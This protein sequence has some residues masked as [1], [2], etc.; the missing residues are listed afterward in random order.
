MQLHPSTSSFALAD[1]SLPHATVRRVV[2]SIRPLPHSRLTKFSVSLVQDVAPFPP[3]PVE[4]VRYIME[5]AATIHR[6][7]ALSL[8]LVST[9]VHAWISPIIY[10]TVSL[11]TTNQV[12]SFRHV[13]HF[14]LALVKSLTLNGLHTDILRKCD[15]VSRLLVAS[16]ARRDSWHELMQSTWS[17]AKP[18]EIHLSYP[19][20][21]EAFSAGRPCFA[22]I[23]HVEI[24]CHDLDEILTCPGVQ[25]LTHLGIW[26]SGP[27]QEDKTHLSIQRILDGGAALDLLVLY[28]WSD[29]RE[30]LARIKDERLL[31]GPIPA[32]NVRRM[33]SE[34]ITTVWD[35]AK[36]NFKE[37]RDPTHE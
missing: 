20:A 13:S 6:P 10:R 31:V 18:R 4:L 7:V 37:W 22:N 12:L 8:S 24:G 30:S 14:N 33:L 35:Y 11:R 21:V 23:T 9:V 25:R 3:L 34:G 19:F 32:P 5:L 36:S 15:N 2:W 28:L 27:M 1:E 16:G 29:G 17:G 26:Y